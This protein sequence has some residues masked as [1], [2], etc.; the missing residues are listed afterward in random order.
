MRRLGLVLGVSVVMAAMVVLIAGSV[1]AKDTQQKQ[2]FVDEVDAKQ[3]FALPGSAASFRGVAND[4]EG[5]RDP[6]LTA[7]I[8]ARIT[9]SGTPGPGVETRLTGG[10]WILCSKF[11][12]PP[13][14]P[15][16]GAL[17]EPVCPSESTIALQGSV[18]DGTAVWDTD[19]GTALVP[20]GLLPPSGPPCIPVY[21][22]AA[23]VEAVFTIAPVGTVNGV[24]V[25]EKGIGHFKG[26]LDHSPFLD[27]KC[28]GDR[29]GLYP[30]TLTGTL[31]LKF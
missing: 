5:D 6:G 31:E 19:G 27:Y 13:R 29:P 24:D 16:T 2:L 11:T 10:T 20:T 9:Y 7:E 4:I 12:A 17:I 22:G 30:A 14:D 21:A 28:P 3:Y 15:N 8:D 25:T 23:D 1:L 26:T 18:R